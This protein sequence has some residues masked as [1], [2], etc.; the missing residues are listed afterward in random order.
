MIQAVISRM[1]GNSF[2]LRGWTVALVGALLAV[3]A[4]ETQVRFAVLALLP[5]IA[6]WVLD[7]YYLRQEHLFRNLYDRI[8]TAPDVE[9]SADPYSMSTKNVEQVSWLEIVRRPVILGLHL[10]ALIAVIIVIAVFW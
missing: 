10:P 7:A 2:Q 8:R 5:A 6:F 3:S 1:A 9:L 4:S